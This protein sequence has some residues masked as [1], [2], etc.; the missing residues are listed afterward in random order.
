MEKIGD[1]APEV[2][3]DLRKYSMLKYL[4]RLIEEYNYTQVKTPDELRGFIERVDEIMAVH[5]EV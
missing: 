1:I 4:G 3:C 2:L 5:R